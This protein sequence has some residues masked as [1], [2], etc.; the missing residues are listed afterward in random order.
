MR[1][2]VLIVAGAIAL[3]LLGL[4]YISPTKQNEDLFGLE[5]HVSRVQTF[6]F[7]FPAMSFKFTR[8]R[9][10]ELDLAKAEESLSHL[11]GQGYRRHTNSSDVMHYPGGREVIRTTLFSHTNPDEPSYFVWNSDRDDWVRLE[12]HRNLA[13]NSP[14]L[15]FAKV[16]RRKSMNVPPS[17]LDDSQVNP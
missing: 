16:F 11:E 6:Y 15:L 3:T 12:I 7:D 1:K 5:P 13:P 17:L 14:E 4:A 10:L 9:L 8:Y 2:R